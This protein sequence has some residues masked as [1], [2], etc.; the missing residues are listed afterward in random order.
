ML[1]EGVRAERA[2]LFVI[3]AVVAIGGLAGGVG[4]GGDGIS[5]STVPGSDVDQSGIGAPTTAGVSGPI[6]G[7]TVSID[8]SPATAWPTSPAAASTGGDTADRETTPIRDRRRTTVG[9]ANTTSGTEPAADSVFWDY[10][11]DSDPTVDDTITVVLNV[12][13]SP[14]GEFCFRET[15]SGGFEK[16]KS[17]IGSDREIVSFFAHVSDDL[18]LETGESTEL[19]GTGPNGRTE[20]KTVTVLS[21]PPG[22]IELDVTRD[23]TSVETLSEIVVS[24]ESGDRLG[25]YSGRNTNG[26]PLPHTIEDLP[27]GET[28]TVEAFVE[29]AFVGSKSVSVEADTT[30]SETITVPDTVP[31]DVSV[32]LDD[33]E[34]AFP[35]ATVEL[36]SDEGTTWHRTVTD[37]NGTT[38]TFDVQ[39]PSTFRSDDYLDVVVRFDGERVG[40]TRLDDPTAGTV[41]VETDVEPRTALGFT[42]GPKSPSSWTAVS[43]A[44]R[45]G[46]RHYWEF[47]DG[48]AAVGKRV[49]HVY[50]E[51][52]T[53]PVTLH[54]DGRTYTREVVVSASS[55]GV[56]SITRETGGVPLAS[57]NYTETFTATFEDGTQFDHVRFDLGNETVTVPQTAETYAA[58]FDLGNLSASNHLTVTAVNESGNNYT[59]RRYV[60]V[61]PVPEWMTWLVHGGSGVSMGVDNGT[62]DM[63]Y[64]PFDLS[65]DFSI[66]GVPLDASAPQFTGGPT[67][68]VEYDSYTRRATGYGSGGFSTDLMGYGFEADVSADATFEERL[69]FVRASARAEASLSAQVGPPMQVDPPYFDPIGVETTV[70]PSLAM[71]GEFNETFAFQNGTVTPGAS[72]TVGTQTPAP[73]GSVGVS[74]TG[75]LEG[76]FD[77]GTP[78]RNLSGEV[79]VE[80]NGWAK[81]SGK[82]LVDFTVGPYNHSL[83]SGTSSLAVAT[84][85]DEADWRL[86]TRHGSVPAPGVPSVDE[87]GSA[88]AA[89]AEL[90]P[91][92]GRTGRFV[93][94]TNRSLEDGQPAIAAT[95]GTVSL[96]WSRQAANKSVA[97]GQD[98]AIRT[99]DDG[100]WGPQTW[101]TDNTVH[102]RRPV[103]AASDDGRLLA[104]WTRI[105][106]PLE[107]FDDPAEAFDDY[108]IAYAVSDGQTW[109]DPTVLENAS[110]RDRSPTVAWTGDGWTL[111]WARDELADVGTNETT[112]TGTDV[113]VASIGTD[114]AAT[115]LDTI[116]NARTPA[117]GPAPE[118]PN[119]SLAY[120]ATDDGATAVERA[121]VDDAVVERNSYP[122]ASVSDL[123]TAGERVAWVEGNVTEPRL[124]E[125][126]AGNASR[127][128]PDDDTAGITGLSLDANGNETVLTYRARL[129]GTGANDLVYRLDRGDG[130]ID[131][132]QFAEPPA[133]DLAVWYPA[134]AL[135]DD[136]T[137]LTTF[138]AT[139]VSAT[140]TNDVFAYEHRFRPRYA[141]SVDGPSDATVG[142]RVPIDYTVSNVGDLNGT[143][144]VNVTIEAG[145]GTT[146]GTSTVDPIRTDATATGTFDVPVPASGRFDLSVEA[147]TTADTEA[148]PTPID[149][150]EAAPPP[151]TATGAHTAASS[152]STGGGSTEAAAVERGADATIR[153]AS[154][155]LSVDVVTVADPENGTIA[156]DIANDGGAVATDVPV[157]IRDGDAV[158]AETTVD[159]VAVDGTA[160]W[161]ATVDPADLD[162]TAPETVEIQPGRS[163]AT[164]AVAEA[165]NRTTWLYR[166]AVTVHEDVT[167][168]N[169]TDGLV[170]RGLVSNAGPIGTEMTVSAVRVGAN[171]TATTTLASDRTAVA[172]GASN[173]TFE[174]V[175][176]HL[177]DDALAVGETVRIVAEPAVP[178]DDPA[179]TATTRTVES[180]TP[181]P[182]T[183]GLAVADVT[184]DPVVGEP[185]SLSVHAENVGMEPTNESLALLVDGNETDDT[186]VALDSGENATATVAWTPETAGNYTLAV[187][188]GDDRVEHTVSV[189]E[190]SGGGLPAPPPSTGGPDV[191]IV[192]HR[193]ATNAIALGDELSVTITVENAGD[194][195]G[196][197]DL[198]LAI[199]GEVATTRQVTVEAGATRTVTL[200][201][202]VETTGTH[203][204]AV[205]GEDVGTVEVS[206]STGSADDTD[207]SDGAAGG[208]ESA[209]DETGAGDGSSV[210]GFGV[211]AALVGLAVALS[212]IGRA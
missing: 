141:L 81:M 206:E 92:A 97:D 80:G 85:A 60:P 58:E 161:N 210:P 31:I 126:R 57:V 1:R 186:G 52:G 170:V 149:G 90:S 59:A 202:A 151:S 108:E 21:Q 115:R 198:P 102:D 44:G 93:R 160:T 26:I 49:A 35:G 122:A 96:A 104:A 29:D 139:N 74:A 38:R 191:S 175:R 56:E 11:P 76:S 42:Y 135:T 144:P 9:T 166:P 172:S 95:N 5:G 156:V 113:A 168:L 32:L 162:R 109:S 197:I 91:S 16:C 94:L 15:G 6:R 54:V 192:D 127:L 22:D 212:R 101:L 88:L 100:E 72:L 105:D 106:T 207:G 20:P 123:A 24:N 3:V 157:A 177:D 128:R 148:A 77:V 146:L 84:T 51:A 169:R 193:L 73:G 155:A 178:N 43:F 39:Q 86:P 12:S 176:F 181:A 82:E 18:G 37:A 133:D 55:G 2:V 110:T 40:S 87:R 158:V 118:S 103:L 53:Y 114:G 154:P 200:S 190:Q 75:G 14:G 211:L 125:G 140:A 159:R 153:V 173:T 184:A 119:A 62:I 199:D 130:W 179:T 65:Y 183:V 13:A 70:T 25:K 41:Q 120:V 117:V 33:G 163:L 45:D 167:V 69:Q 111:A 137:F 4:A 78:E 23:G 107:S 129:N 152:P 138:A 171:G 131:D 203:E 10:P 68:G 201:T 71:E 204:V 83:G 136:G 195:A 48:E 143:A 189:T 147:G 205:A 208:T 36:V 187:E 98:I 116:A 28:Y 27:S 34:T 112:V 150:T 145:N 188:S 67:V 209:G 63:A 174:S 164:D 50:E 64:R 134:T 8:G 66:G 142:D 132:H 89:T 180:V 7:S 121:S 30:H 17:D 61:Q 196:T 182:A 46:D 194:A 165:G 185:V 99:R 19:V 79:W 124:V 47:G